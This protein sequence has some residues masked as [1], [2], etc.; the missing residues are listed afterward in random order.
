MRHYIYLI[1]LGLFECLFAK[2]LTWLK[3]FFALGELVIFVD[4]SFTE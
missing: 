3:F 1:E 4:A 2:E